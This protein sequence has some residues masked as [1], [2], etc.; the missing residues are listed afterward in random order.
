MAG[1][2]IKTPVKVE[3]MDAEVCRMVGGTV[4]PDGKCKLR[5]VVDETKPRVI[6]IEGIR[7]DELTD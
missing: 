1:R 7:E 2:I 3:N 5:M 6:S 4:T